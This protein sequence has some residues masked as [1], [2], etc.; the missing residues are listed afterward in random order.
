MHHTTQIDIEEATQRYAKA[1]TADMIAKNKI[2]KNQI[3]QQ[4]THHEVVLAFQD[5]QALRYQN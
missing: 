5:L 1:L 4:K 3:E 2:V